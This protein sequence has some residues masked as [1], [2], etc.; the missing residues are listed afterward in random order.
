MPIE[1]GMGEVSSYSVPS[2]FK[3]DLHARPEGPSIGKNNYKL[4]ADKI[5]YE[6]CTNTSQFSMSQRNTTGTH[7][8]VAVMCFA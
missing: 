4:F 8:N 5:L 1:L 2:G 6:I 3:A 7:L